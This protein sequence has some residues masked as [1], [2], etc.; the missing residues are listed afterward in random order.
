MFYKLLLFLISFIGLFGLTLIILKKYLWANLYECFSKKNIQNET[1]ILFLSI[2]WFITLGLIGVICSL[3]FYLNLTN[4]YARI[5]LLIIGLIGILYVFLKRHNLKDF[6]NIQNYKKKFSNILI[7]E[8][9]IILII[10][11]I[12]SIFLYKSLIPWFD[13]DEISQYGYSTL[14][15]S[16]DWKIS[17]DFYNV[18]LGFGEILYAPFYWVTENTLL[19]RFIRS[20][21]ILF[22]AFAFY[23]I[24]R[25]LSASRFISLLGSAAFLATPE[26]A[27]IGVSMKVDVVL[28]GFELM[29]LL[30]FSLAIFSINFNGLLKIEFPK[31]INKFFLFSIIFG[32]LAMSS[33][34]SGLYS[35]ILVTFIGLPIIILNSKNSLT[36]FKYL[37]TI[38]TP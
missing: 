18:L 5:L 3:F 25:F 14:L 10:L 24:C 8:K 21:G 17:D 34:N 4:Y 6:I 35:L 30:L 27:V 22:N 11:F 2:C 31:F 37:F 23:S 26:L 1:I 19:P 28:L 20:T 32:L 12:Y 9:I 33:R 13:Q 29:A 16:N 38:V 36:S 7:K 15:I